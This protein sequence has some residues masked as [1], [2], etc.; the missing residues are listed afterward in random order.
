MCGLKS[1]ARRIVLK[2]QLKLVT[3]GC[4]WKLHRILWYSVGLYSTYC[5]FQMFCICH[6]YEH[7][8]L[9]RI[10]TRNS[11]SDNSEAL[12]NIS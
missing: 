12:C 8:V 2:L 3:T 9:V 11:R 10:F 7:T 1:D 4:V 5:L 6:D